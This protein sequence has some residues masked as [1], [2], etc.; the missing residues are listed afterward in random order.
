MKNKKTVIILLIVFIVLIAGASVLYNLLDDVVEPEQI[1]VHDHDHHSEKEESPSPNEFSAPDFSVTDINGNIVSLLDFS[2][3]PVIL[4]FW[5]SWCGPCKMEMPFFDDA[6]RT[7]KDNIHF[8]MIN[9]TDGSRETIRSASEYIKEE[10]YIFPI[11]FDSSAEAA[12]KYGVSGIPMT[13]FI[14]KNGNIVAYAQ[15]AIDRET[16][17]RGIDMIYTP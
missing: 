3:K 10:G 14:D 16:L 17:Q 2:G 6:Y 11:Y 7:Y 9:M 12:V 13:I 1:A 5:A 4:N 15:S 8:L